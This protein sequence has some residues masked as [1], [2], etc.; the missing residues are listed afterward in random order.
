MSATT[1]ACRETEPAAQVPLTVERAAEFVDNKIRPVVN[2][3]DDD[4]RMPQH[5]LNAVTELG[6]WAPFLPTEYGGQN[7]NWVTLGKIHEEINRGCT[8]LRSILTAHVMVALAI[9]QWGTDDQRAQWLRPLCTGMLAS[10]CLTGFESGSAADLSGTVATPDGSGWLINGRKRW[11][12]SAQ[13]SGV[14]LVFAHTPH[15]PTAFL[16]P[17]DNPGVS[18]TPILG[19]LGARANLLGEYVFTDVRVGEDAVLG[20]IGWAKPTVMTHALALGRYSVACG[21]AGIIQAVLDECV[22][23]TEQRVVPAGRLS[24]QQLVRR[25]I[26]NMVTGLRASRL[27]YGEVGRLRD[28]NDPAAI[29]E[30]WVAKYFASEAAD[31]AASDGVQL[32]GAAGCAPGAPTARFFRDAKPLSIIEGTTEL[33][34]TTI[35]DIAYRRTSR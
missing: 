2:A 34:Q 22:R 10:F 26:S 18:S 32:L 31:R 8:S 7:M 23:Y 14:A 13:V 30:S 6:L 12:T 15:G 5:I 21:S 20:P 17:R 25:K 9:N 1:S 11:A 4:G 16:V 28:A 3:Y 27:L 29:L 24:D 19:M 33:Q 35:A